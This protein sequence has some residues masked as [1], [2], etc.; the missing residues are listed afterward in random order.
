MCEI[1]RRQG[2]LEPRRLVVPRIHRS[3]ALRGSV[4]ALGLLGAKLADPHRCRG[5]ERAQALVHVREDRIELT[6]GALARGTT[7]APVVAVD[8]EHIDELTTRP[9]AGQGNR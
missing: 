3:R 6:P 1:A 8:A 2:V 9:H 5:M 4:V 7:I